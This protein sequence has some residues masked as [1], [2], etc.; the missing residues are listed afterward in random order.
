MTTTVE[1]LRRQPLGDPLRGVSLSQ[2]DEAVRLIREVAPSN[3]DIVIKRDE[4][5]GQWF[6]VA[7]WQEE[8]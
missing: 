5:I 7:C 4:L 3:A 6:L 1:I 8:R 2:L